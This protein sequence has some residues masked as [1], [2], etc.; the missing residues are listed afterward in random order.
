[1]D[2]LVLMLIWM[3]KTTVRICLGVMSGLGYILGA[4]YDVMFVGSVRRG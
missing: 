1:M 3:R 2:A 4:G